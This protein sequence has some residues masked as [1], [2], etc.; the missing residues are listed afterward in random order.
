MVTLANLVLATALAAVGLASVIPPKIGTTAL[1]N[2]HGTSSGRASLKQVRRPG[3]RF[4]GARDIYKTYLKYGVPVPDYLKNAVANI[5]ALNAAALSKRENGSAA[6]I[7]I[8]PRFDIAYVT[9]VTIGTPPQTL[10]LDFDTG[11]SDLWVF[12]S[13][14]PESQVRGQRIYSPEKSSTAKLLAGHTWSILYGDG[15]GSLGNVYTD[16]FTVGGVTVTSQAV[17]TAQQVSYSFTSQSEIH[18]L[19][20]LG[21]S[22]LNTVFPNGQLTFFDNAKS[23]LDSPVFTADLK[24]KKEGTYDFGF[25]DETKYTGEITYLPVQTDPGYWTFTSSGYAVGDGAFH[26]ASIVGIADTGTSLTYL[27]AEVVTSYWGQVDGA[28]DSDY[29]GGYVFPCSSKL[30]SFTFGVGPANITIPA[31]YINYAQ[32]TEGSPV[33]FGGLQSSSWLGVNIWGDVALKAA[34]V[35]F[36]GANP[37]TIGWAKKPLEQ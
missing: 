25:I 20:G 15:S 11:S 12:S 10:Y 34:F 4:N 14:T 5:D 21:F 35:V 37:P 36:N 19:V 6:A 9:P 28:V 24:W 29:Y 23:T 32:I 18:G 13:H 7:P 16:N 30:P 31:S 8:D 33:C 26:P 3:Y 17:Q 22:T 2:G 1:G 27:P